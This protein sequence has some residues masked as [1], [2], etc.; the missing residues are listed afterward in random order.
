LGRLK[1][2]LGIIYDWKQDKAGNTYLESS[3]PKMI[4]DISYK[5]EIALGKKAKIYVTP[6]MPG[7]TLVN[8]TVPMVEL[9]AYRSIV[10]K[11]I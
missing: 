10:G 4:E 8:S 5:L 2:H 3:M 11:I 7:K 6:R 9:D 1:K